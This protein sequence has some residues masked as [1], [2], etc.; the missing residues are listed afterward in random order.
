MDTNERSRQ[1]H[2]AVTTT[3]VEPGSADGR[4]TTRRRALRLLGAAAAG[5]MATAAVSNKAAAD[6]GITLAAAVTDT[7]NMVRVNYTGATTGASFVFQ[8]GTLNTGTD[9]SHPAALAGWSSV[10]NAPSGVYGHTN[11]GAAFGVIGLN[12]SGSP[13]GSGVGGICPTGFGGNFS[14]AVGLIGNGVI[15]MKTAGTEVGLYAVGGKA[16][17]CIEPINAPPPPARNVANDDGFVSRDSN[18]DLW[19]CIKSGT[20][21]TWRKLT[22]P[23]T[24]G[25]FH[26]IAPTR[27]YDSRQAQPSPG[28]LATGQS[29]TISVKDARAVNGGAVTTANA[30]PAGATAIAANI[31]ISATT[32]TGYLAVNP[33]GATAITASTINWFGPNQTIA[34]GVTLTLNANRELTVVADGGGSTHFIVDITGFYL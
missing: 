21:G 13:I 14:G 24:A 16:A 27:V 31:T 15:G 17:M 19:M 30:I 10:A 18:G 4:G 9:A 3:E 28:L 33:G 7:P 25:A 8:A 29:R 32:G 1:L 5:G 34:N 12:E 23:S 11:Q 20:P 6:S 22:G 2:P 26:A